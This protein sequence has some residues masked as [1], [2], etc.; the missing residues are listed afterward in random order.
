MPALLQEMKEVARYYPR[1]AWRTQL[2]EPGEMTG[3]PPQLW[4]PHRQ[5]WIIPKFAPDHPYSPPHI[6]LSPEIRS[7]HYYVHEGES[8]ARLCWCKP[9]DWHPRMRLIIAVTSAMRFINDRRAGLV[10]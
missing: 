9:S 6:Y 8:T 1:S 10:D 5:F 3:L 4:V 7:R 2:L